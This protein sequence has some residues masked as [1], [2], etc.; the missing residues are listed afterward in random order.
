MNQFG[1]IG[2]SKQANSDLLNYQIYGMIS[3]T[4]HTFRCG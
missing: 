4:N 3:Y 2:N 1:I